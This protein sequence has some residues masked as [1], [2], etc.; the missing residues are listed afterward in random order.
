MGSKKMEAKF[1]AKTSGQYLVC[2]KNQAR[3]TVKITVDLHS[4][5]WSDKFTDDNQAITQKQLRPVE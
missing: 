3:E 4:G 5:A 2:L 1:D